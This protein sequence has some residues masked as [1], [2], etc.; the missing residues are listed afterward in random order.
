MNIWQSYGWH[1]GVLFLSLTVYIVDYD[2]V[3]HRA[4]KTFSVNVLRW[5]WTK[6]ACRFSVI[7]NVPELNWFDVRIA[8]DSTLNLRTLSRTCFAAAI[9]FVIFLW[10]EP[11]VLCITVL[12]SRHGFYSAIAC[13]IYILL[14]N[15]R[16]FH[17][18]HITTSYAAF[19]YR[20]L[21]SLLL[22]SLSTLTVQLLQAFDRRNFTVNV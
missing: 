2:L 6:H 19:G 17:C 8:V 4:M 13:L 11:E 14:H 21:V 22:L 12:C 15:K 5:K 20:V 16:T 3:L 10:F 9:Q 1:C 7:S 18:V